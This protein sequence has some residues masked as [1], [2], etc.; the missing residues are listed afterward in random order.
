MHTENGS[1]NNS[2]ERKT[3]EN[4]CEGVPDRLADGLA[5]FIVKSV[6]VGNVGNFVVAAEK[7]YTVWVFDFE[8][9]EE[10]QD[11]D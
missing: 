4:I 2:S 3:R 10:A 9:Q 1:I 7:E 11:F 5:A 8:A 6:I